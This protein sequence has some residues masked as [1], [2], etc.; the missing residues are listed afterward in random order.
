[1]KKKNQVRN[2]TH[3]LFVKRYTPNQKVMIKPDGT[4]VYQ[5]EEVEVAEVNLGSIAHP[6]RDII[7]IKLIPMQFEN[8][9][10]IFRKDY[11]RQKTFKDF[12]DNL[13][14]NSEDEE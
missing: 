5:V 10:G 4:H 8:A 1:M 12:I 14:D 3:R 11:R 6:N 9:G 7:E 2:P 13:F